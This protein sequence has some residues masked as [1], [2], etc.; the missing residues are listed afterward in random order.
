MQK[1]IWEKRESGGEINVRSPR[2]RAARLQPKQLNR[3]W[4]QMNAKGN[5]LPEG[6][7]E[8]YREIL[9]TR[10]QSGTLTEWGAP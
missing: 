3:E 10:E 8:F 9:E 7:R 2:L 4:T 6:G 5:D 1:C